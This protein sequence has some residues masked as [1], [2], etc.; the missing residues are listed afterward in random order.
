VI[1]APL[2]ICSHHGSEPAVGICVRCQAPLCKAC[3][4][5]IDGINHCKDCLD[6]LAEPPVVAAKPLAAPGR[7]G[8][9][10]GV[11]VLSALSWL[12][13]TALLPEGP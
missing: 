8:L 4:T 12:S 10:F 5:K 1:E 3:I 2:A 13:L 7:L 9:V 11:F 6:Q